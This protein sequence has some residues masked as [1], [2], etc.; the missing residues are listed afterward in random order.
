MTAAQRQ[1]LKSKIL[2]AASPSRGQV[3]VTVA[4]FAHETSSSP[5]VSSGKAAALPP[6]AP[7]VL[8]ELP[9]PYMP[10]PPKKKVVGPSSSAAPTTKITL[11]TATKPIES[12]S[13]GFAPKPPSQAAAIAQQQQQSGPKLPPIP[14]ASQMRTATD[15]AAKVLPAAAKPAAAVA[16]KPSFAS[17]SMPP[18][19]SRTQMAEAGKLMANLDTGAAKPASTSQPPIPSAAAAKV[20]F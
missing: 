8:P 15:L 18:M 19:P 16:P 6:L 10:A 5:A 3:R 12:T 17:S 9:K 14:T 7:L 13:T 4:R 11:K 20:L 2:H 1:A